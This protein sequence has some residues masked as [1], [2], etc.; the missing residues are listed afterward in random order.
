MVQAWE[1]ERNNRNFQRMFEVVVR[2]WMEG[3]LADPEVEPWAAF[4]DRV[5]QALARLTRV[6][7]SRQ[8]VAFTSGGVIG[9]M[10]QTVLRAPDTAAIELNW[11][12]RNG[13]LTGF[14]FSGGRISL[15]YFNATPHLEEGEISFR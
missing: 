2:H 8:V 9:V 11:R 7:P 5:C 6:G 1:R 12:V 15:D 13:S 10:V 14:L 4:R 3:T